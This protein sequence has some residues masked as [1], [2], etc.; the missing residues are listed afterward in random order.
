MM[1]LAQAGETFVLFGPAHM[2][3]L[4]LTVLVPAGLILWTRR[5][6]PGVGRAAHSL[7]TVFNATIN[8]SDSSG[9]TR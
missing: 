3:V 1:I 7:S 5:A 4:A 6:G 2:V 8:T 9:L